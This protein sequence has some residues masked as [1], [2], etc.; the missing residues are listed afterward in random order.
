MKVINVV[1]SKDQEYKL[2]SLNRSDVEEKAASFIE[3]DLN[4]EQTAFFLTNKEIHIEAPISLGETTINADFYMKY[5]GEFIS[6]YLFSGY[7]EISIEQNILKM[8]L[9]AVFYPASKKIS[10]ITIIA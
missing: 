5:S 7:Y 8:S 2:I 3:F 4:D 6:T 1:V 10:I 9:A